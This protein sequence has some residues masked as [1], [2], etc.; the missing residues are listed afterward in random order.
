V[1]YFLDVSDVSVEWEDTGGCSGRWAGPAS[2]KAFKRLLGA[3]IRR[4]QTTTPTPSTED[5]GRYGTEHDITISNP[6]HLVLCCSDDVLCFI[7]LKLFFF[8]LNLY[9]QN[10]FLL[11]LAPKEIIFS[12]SLLFN[13][14]HFLRIL[15]NIIYIINQLLQINNDL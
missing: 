4:P 13:Y 1:F 11:F 7:L 3:I 5:I 10:F 2:N 8:Y 15:I 12:G 6:P 14:V 9:F